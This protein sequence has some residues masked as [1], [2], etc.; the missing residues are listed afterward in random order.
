M[1]QVRRV[2]GA[3]IVV[4]ALAYAFAPAPSG[5]ALLNTAG[6]WWRAQGEVPLRL[7]PP[8]HVPPGGLAVGNNFEGATAISAVRFELEPEETNP[9]L[10]LTV[11]NSFAGPDV[12]MAA[13]HAGS[14]WFGTQAGS[15][16]DAP[17]AACGLGSA[18]GIASDDG[19]SWT[20]PLGS[21]QLEGLVD[22]V[23]V[24]ADDETAP[25]EISFE[26]P[27]SAS[28]Q[29]TTDSAGGGFTGPPPAPPDFF[30]PPGFE[31]F[32]GFTDPAQTQPFTPALT[33][34][35]QQPRA[36]AP[37]SQSQE[38]TFGESTANL[39]QVADDSDPRPL[40]LVVLLGGLAL[41]AF[42]MREPLPTPRLLGPMATHRTDRAPAEPADS[43]GL[44]RF[45]RPRHGRPRAL[46]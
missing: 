31:E 5:A 32:G 29:T 12:K 40:A 4:G 28:L 8:P 24:P 23:I 34:Q 35:E 27:T 22:V 3:V 26:A 38:R 11:A 33:P 39:L 36:D 13:C 6:W 43:R 46:L 2:L 14:A 16:S 19:T 42:L 41:G 1:R 37:V 20:F 10:T 30:V 17:T 45:H 7:E 9:I 25:F 21:L 15:W 18:Q 44:G